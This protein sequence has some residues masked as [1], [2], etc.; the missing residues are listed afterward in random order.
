[1]MVRAIKDLIQSSMDRIFREGNHI[2]DWLHKLGK[3]LPLGFHYLEDPLGDV[4]NIL[5]D[6]DRGSSHN[7]LCNV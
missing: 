3:D 7:R 6:D 2:A 4:R 1:M 5:F